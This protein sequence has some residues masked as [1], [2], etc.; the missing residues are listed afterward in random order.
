MN[1]SLLIQVIAWAL[2]TNDPLLTQVNNGSL[3]TQF[4]NQDVLFLQLVP[5]LAY[6]QLY[7]LPPR[8]LD[9]LAR[10]LINHLINSKYM[11]FAGREVRIAKN[12]ARGLA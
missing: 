5:D 6:K 1:G 11:L 4:T 2:E 7:E 12:C 9:R 8:L 3:Y 10:W